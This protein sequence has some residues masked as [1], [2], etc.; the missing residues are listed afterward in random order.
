MSLSNYPARTQTIITWLFNVHK[1]L[2]TL[3]TAYSC[4]QN[5]STPLTFPNDFYRNKSCN[6]DCCVN[7]KLPI[8]QNMIVS[9]GLEL[10][11]SMFRRTTM[12][13]QHPLI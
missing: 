5:Y 9:Q 2:Q 7:S 6:I 3:N 8:N 4:T 12:S 13:G 10:I 11:L 1:C